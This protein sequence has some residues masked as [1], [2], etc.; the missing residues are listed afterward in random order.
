MSVEDGRWLHVSELESS[1]ADG[2]SLNKSLLPDLIRGTNFNSVGGKSEVP[3]HDQVLK[4][5]NEIFADCWEG[6]L[7]NGNLVVEEEDERIFDSGLRWF[8][9]PSEAAH[10]LATG[11]VLSN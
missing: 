6:S 2:E 3:K 11:Q 1:G 9:L 5:S 8:L 7:G 10:F 4:R